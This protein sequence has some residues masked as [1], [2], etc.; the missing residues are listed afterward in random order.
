MQE[1]IYI[2]LKD[3][4]YAAVSKVKGNKITKIT[5]QTN[6]KNCP[7]PSPTL[8]LTTFIFTYIQ[9]NRVLLSCLIHVED[10]PAVSGLPLSL[11]NPQRTWVP[12]G[13]SL[14]TPT[15]SDLAQEWEFLA[16]SCHSHHLSYLLDSRPC[17]PRVITSTCLFLV[18]LAS[19]D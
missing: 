17:P 16:H 9:I 19:L 15:E 2:S 3:W 18:Q 14:M 13:N 11:I 12:T 1:I 4:A 10:I 5:N 6:Q 7:F 8:F